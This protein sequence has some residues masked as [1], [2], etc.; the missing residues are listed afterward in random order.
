MNHFY[1]IYEDTDDIRE[2]YAF[3]S[4]KAKNWDGRY[5]VRDMSG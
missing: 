2:F 5:P 4:G 1:E 3:L